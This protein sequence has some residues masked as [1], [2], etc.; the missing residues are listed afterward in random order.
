MNN[1]RR[2]TQELTY[3]APA[4][5]NDFGEEAF[6]P[7]EVISGRWENRQDNVVSAS[8]EEI[9]SK[10][11]AYVD[12][13]LAVEG[14]LALGNHVGQANPTLVSGAEQIKGTIEVSSLRT[15]TEVKAVIL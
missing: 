13:T 3:W 11:F 10:A 9:V 5:E 8:G 6:A 12:A 15:N 2:Y 14:Y 4:T 1:R 7:P